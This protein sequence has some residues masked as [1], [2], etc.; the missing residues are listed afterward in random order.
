MLAREY[1]RVSVDRSGRRRSNEEQQSDNRAAWP[2]FTWGEHFS[3]AG[4]ASRY[5]DR[6]RDDF[7]WLIAELE[8]D[9]FGAEILVLWE[10]SRGSRKVG[11]WVQLLDLCESRC[12]R[13]AVTEH[14]RIYDPTNP[15]DRRTLLED[16]VDSEY[17]SA[18][19]S[20]RVRRSARSAAA[21]RRPHGKVLFGY[22]RIYDA[23]SGALVGQE[24]EPDQAPVVRWIFACY[25]AG[26]SARSLAEALNRNGV[27][28]NRGNGWTPLMV[29]R[30]LTNRGY[31]GRRMHKGEDFGQGWEPLV[32]E[33]TF[34]AVQRRREATTWR[35]VRRTSALCSGVARCG[36][37]GG[38][39]EIKHSGGVVR[40]GCQE[41]Y[42]AYRRADQLDAWVTAAVVTRLSMPD[43]DDRLRSREDPRL[44]ESRARRDDLRSQLDE[45]MERWKAGQLSVQGYAEME[46]H[47][48]TQLA[49][50]ERQLRRE[51]IPIALDVPAPERVAAWW[52][53]LTH[54]VKRAV[55]SAL[56]VA[57]HVQP[58]GR[59][60]K[61]IE[62]SATT[63]I[64]WRH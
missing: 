36:V 13:I 48:R 46:S 6:P 38:R 10:A 35:K 39:M 32:E 28:T 64:E 45:A 37:C 8:H 1:L 53:G 3:D 30:M 52:D 59:G 15:R 33:A 34:E 49:E 44:N 11:E 63:A 41:G 25:L 19:T 58:V 31:L 55:I 7:D 9:R 2:D 14:R 12:V 47:L 5:A 27:T 50:V 57:I 20:G 43:V 29:H 21:A 22:R 62:W 54:E 61:H 17:E 4:S 51:T 40:Y 56:I 24:P 26:Q 23:R 18:K 42:H 16:A 60:C